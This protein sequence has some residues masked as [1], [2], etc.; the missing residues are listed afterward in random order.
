MDLQHITL[1]SFGYIEKDFLEKIAED[2]RREY[3]LPV[4]I[5]EGHLDLSEFHDPARRQY[6]GN[7]LLKVVDSMF[8][9]ESLK[10]LGLFSVDLFIPILTYIFGQAYLNGRTGIASFHRFN[11]E[12]YGMK[13]DDKIMLDRFRKEVIHELGHTFGLIH[14]HVP[15]C[16]M[17]SSTYV[18]DIDQKS[19]N[20]CIT[21]R[22]KLGK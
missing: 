8:S 15:T 12:R 9:S 3:I 13:K 2:V 20:L 11:N 6:N 14:C 1:I 17:R 22:T 21:C 19:P 5:R 18:E 16:V 7:N 4:K 10:I